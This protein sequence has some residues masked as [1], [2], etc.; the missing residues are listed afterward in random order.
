[1][2]TF[3]IVILI[4]FFQIFLAF[5]INDSIYRTGNY[6][7]GRIKFD[8]YIRSLEYENLL[9]KIQEQRN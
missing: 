1:M 8:S 5:Q 6:L 9:N 7:E 3:F 2:K 4:L